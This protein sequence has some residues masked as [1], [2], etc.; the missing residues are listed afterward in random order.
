MKKDAETLAKEYEVGDSPSDYYNYIV[1]SMINGNRAQVK[2]LF[3]QMTPFCKRVFLIDFLSNTSG[4]EIST[5]NV[6]IIALVN[7]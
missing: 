7:D 6:C 4:I 1:D 2:A 5:R 3:L